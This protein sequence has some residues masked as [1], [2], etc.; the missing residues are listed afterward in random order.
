M[1]LEFDKTQRGFAIGEF[2]DRNGVK[3]S[4][5]ESSEMYDEG[6]IWLGCND[7]ELKRFVPGEGW[8]DVP[9]EHNPP[10]GICH[11]ANTRMHLTQSMVRELL[12]ALQYFAETGELPKSK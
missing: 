4:L 5:Q 11:S 9:L 6:L 8:S 1:S 2:T 7:I 10:H 12:P 3:C